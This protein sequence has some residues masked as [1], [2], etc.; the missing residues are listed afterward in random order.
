[1]KHWRSRGRQRGL[2]SPKDPWGDA[3]CP[4]VICPEPGCGAK[5]LKRDF[6][7][8]I[9]EHLRRRNGV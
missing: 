9:A 5:V 8:H 4:W 1:V 3:G 7:A 2:L 6:L